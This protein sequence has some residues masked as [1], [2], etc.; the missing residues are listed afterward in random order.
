M[1]LHSAGSE[2]K[3]AIPAL[4]EALKDSDPQVRTWAAVALTKNQA[5][6]KAAVP[7]LIQALQDE[8]PMLR[9]VVCL[10][11]GVIPYDDSDKESVVPALAETAGRDV[12]EGVRQAARSALSVIAPELAQKLDT[13]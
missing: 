3:A 13:K 7:V 12:D 9:Q 2:A 11:L 1:G 6:D 10:S 4:R 5:Y 8:N